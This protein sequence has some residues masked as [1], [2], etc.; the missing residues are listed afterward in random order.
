[1]IIYLRAVSIQSVCHKTD[2]QKSG[3]IDT[4]ILWHG[5]ILTFWVTKRQQQLVGEGGQPAGLPECQGRG[6]VLFCSN[7]LRLHQF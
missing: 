5:F 2:R 7:V 3:K 6:P 4:L 1:M